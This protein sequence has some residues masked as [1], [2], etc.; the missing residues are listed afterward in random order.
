VPI[1]DT[2]NQEIRLSGTR[3]QV[4]VSAV[5]GNAVEDSPEEIRDKLETLTNNDRLDASA[6]KNLPQ[7][8]WNST[9]W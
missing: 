5:L 2:G 3:R 9:N 8:Q 4:I 7:F 1:I 6:I